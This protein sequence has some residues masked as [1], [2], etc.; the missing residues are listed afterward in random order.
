LQY[1]AKQLAA[2][3]TPRTIARYLACLRHFYQFC[4]DE[5]WCA[6]NP[7]CHIKTPKLGRPLPH[8]LTEQEVE[9]LLNTPDLKTPLGL[10]DKTILELI[11]ACGL[12]VS[13]CLSLTLPQVNLRQGVVR[14]YGKGQ[15]ER[16]V[17]FGE[18]ASHWLDNYL[19]R[20]RP[21][22][23]QQG[24]SP[25]LFPGRKD[26]PLSRQAFW[27]RIKTYA[28]QANIKKPLSPHTLRHA[29]ATHLVNHGANLRAVQLLLGH[30]SLSS[31]QIYTHVALA[32]LKTLH[33]HHHPRG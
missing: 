10:R 33:Q 9:T 5:N 20:T 15:K 2:E 30:N 27:Y 28:S 7:S 6:E 3:T 23:L 11:Y 24:T 29:F 1:F 19:T 25:I 31:T 16:I 22:L 8:T 4:V 32:R 13:E 18:E 12:R 17:P 14:L 21:R 26:K